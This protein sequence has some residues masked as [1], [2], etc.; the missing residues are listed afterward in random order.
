MKKYRYGRRSR[1]HLKR[2]L[3][4]IATISLVV[5]GGLAFMLKM[6]VSS[7][8]DH[9]KRLDFNGPSQ[10]VGSIA[11]ATVSPNITINQ[12]TYSF[13]LPKSWVQTAEQNIPTREFITWSD[14]T[15]A[16]PDQTLTIYEDKIP[17][18]DSVSFNQLLPVT[19]NGNRLNYST[20]SDNCSN[21]TDGSDSANLA[22]VL[23]K[24]QGVSFYCN[25]QDKVDIEIG[26]G[27]V[28][29]INGVNITGTNDGAHTYFFLYVNRQL[30]PD[31]TT[32]YSILSTFRAK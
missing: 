25:F 3:F 14:S 4:I 9:S 2:H 15:S 19:A 7:D 32:F 8:L 31:L 10:V 6:S 17:V 16:E 18:N 5:V 28:G 12:P 23:A 1:F 13:S 22:P 26:T 24:W 11:S 27:S 20:L 29:T 30:S 21:F